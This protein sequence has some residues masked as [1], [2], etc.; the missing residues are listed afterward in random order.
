MRTSMFVA[1]A[2]FAPAFWTANDP[3]VGKWTLDASRST[4]VDDM[5][6]EALGRN[7]YAFNF[8]GGPAETI[9]ADGTDQP[10]QPGTTVSVK[11]E[12]ARTLMV[13]RKQ[14]GRIIIS[15]HWKLSPDGRTLHDK[16][17]SFQRD[18]SSATVDY[19]YKRMSGT[20][21]FGGSWESRTKPVGLNL[22]LEIQP[23]DEKGLTFI[24][25]GP[26][27]SVIFDG[28]ERASPGAKDSLTLSG[29]RRGARSLEYLENNQG[30]VERARQF[31]LSRDGQIL[32]ETLHVAGQR[33]SD[34]F[35]FERE[36]VRGD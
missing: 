23:Y 4:I 12:D 9:V 25:A 2:S 6:V 24:S 34:V 5:R 13:V 26:N 11:A 27:R 20:S 21:G 14:N 18:G 16:L 33:T 30:K 3:F 7:R 29:R 36:Q 1:V 17:T 22:A 19:V 35:V 31:E 8:E 28:R 32:T 15:A 10:G